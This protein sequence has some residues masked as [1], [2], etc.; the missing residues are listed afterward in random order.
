[1]AGTIR[2]TSMSTFED[3][4]GDLELVLPSTTARPANYW[5]VP[6]WW[7]TNERTI[8]EHCARVDNT[9]TGDS[10]YISSETNFPNIYIEYDGTNYTFDSDRSRS[11]VDRIWITSDPALK[12]GDDYICPLR[13]KEITKVA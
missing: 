1:M 4:S 10:I 7:G 12:A 3:Q 11:H 6:R 5:S 13:R 9:A 8:Y 2:V